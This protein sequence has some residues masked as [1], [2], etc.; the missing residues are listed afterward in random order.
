MPVDSLHPCF[1]DMEDTYKFMRDI[2]AGNVRNKAYIPETYVGEMA[3]TRNK[4]VRQRAVFVNFTKRTLD[5]HLGMIFS[6]PP[7]IEV[8]PLL[9]YVKTDTTGNKL[10]I[11]QTARKMVSEI[12]ITGRIHAFVDYPDG[13]IGLSAAQQELV[14]NLVPRV[15]LYRAEDAPN[16]RTIS[17]SGEDLLSLAVLIEEVADIDPA[18]KFKWKTVKQYRVL[19]LDDEGYYQVDVLNAKG[20]QVVLNGIPSHYEPRENGKRMRRIPLF[21]AGAENNDI[22]TV[23][24]PPLKSMADLNMGHLKHSAGYMEAALLCGQ[25]TIFFTA[26]MTQSMEERM[27][28]APITLGSAKAHYLGRSG[29]VNMVQANETNMD[30]RGMEMIQTQMIMTGAAIIQPNGPAE[31]ATTAL[32]NKTSEVS[33]LETVVSNVED[34]I[35]LCLKQQARYMGASEEGIS[36]QLNHVFVQPGADPLIMTQMNLGIVNSIVPLQVVR[37]YWRD[38]DLIPDDLTDEDLDALITK[39]GLGLQPL[40]NQLPDIPNENN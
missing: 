25:P 5:A 10:T 12:D 22:N 17:E 38:H 7:K 40:N 23:S 34:C 14:P 37:Q 35:V 13:P 19:S 30:S 8:P 1:E 16:W 27:K 28:T 15:Y 11:E 9:E 31:T 6:S 4:R 33:V 2:I 18:D 24:Q 3:A 36:F 39:E 20:Q 29:S 26:E 32:L 21:T